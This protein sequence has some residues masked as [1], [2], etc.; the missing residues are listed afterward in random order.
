MAYIGNYKGCYK[1]T[2]CFVSNNKKEPSL[3]R[4]SSLAHKLFPK[5]LNLGCTY[6]LKLS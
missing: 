2:S 6:D 3:C 1:D 5:R 4:D